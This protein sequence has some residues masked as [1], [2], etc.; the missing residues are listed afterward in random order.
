M[1]QETAIFIQHINH[2]IEEVE[3]DVSDRK[4][5]VESLELKLVE[6]E[7]EML[8]KERQLSELQAKCK[9]VKTTMWLERKHFD[10]QIQQMTAAQ[11]SSKD[12]QHE[13]QVKLLPILCIEFHYIECGN[14]LPFLPAEP[15]NFTT[16]G[17]CAPEE[18]DR[19]DD[20]TV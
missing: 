7:K 10:M 4:T 16:R 6:Q 18:G 14:K 9:E 5:E 11:K 2:L 8:E 12:L 13:L 19:H 20:Q 17:S 15:N 3:S 1:L